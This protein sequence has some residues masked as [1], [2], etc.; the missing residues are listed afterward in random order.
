MPHGIH[1]L[2]AACRYSGRR[3]FSN[4]P[5]A[6]GYGARGM[7][8]HVDAADREVAVIAMIEDP[9]AI[10]CIDAI[11]AVEGLDGVFV[12]RGDLGVAFNDR[13][14]GAPR[15]RAATDKVIAAARRAGKAVCLLA[16]NAAEAREFR[17]RGV[18]AF[19]ISSDQGFMRS[20]ATAALTDFR[21]AVAPAT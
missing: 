18:N 11:V 21:A 4:S 7:W 5:R 3:G 12:G 6:S 8:Q 10:D 19:V 1:S 9:E 15:V 13:E 20:A 16:A 2:V 17:S 14:V